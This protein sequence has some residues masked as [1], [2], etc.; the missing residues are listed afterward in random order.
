M[1]V[2]ILTVLPVA[3]VF[4]FFVV[5]LFVFVGAG[6]PSHGSFMLLV[7]MHFG[8]MVLTWCL[9]AFYIFFLFTTDYVKQD[10]KALWAVVLFLGNMFVMPVFWYIYIWKPADDA[11]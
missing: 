5:I 11:F 4:L 8:V 6:N 3:Y 1:F 9:I 10:H 2:G 7:V